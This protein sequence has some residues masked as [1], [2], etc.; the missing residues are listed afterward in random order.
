MLTIKFS[1]KGKKKH[2]FFK[3]IILEKSKD[4]YG[5]FL[6]DLGFH[7]PFSKQTSLKVDRIKY[8]LSHGA[9]TTP[10]VH[11]LLVDQGVVEGEKMR[12]SKKH[13]VKK[14]EGEEKKAEK[15]E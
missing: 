4:V 13:K 9:Q 6:E 8:W 10:V 14:D 11:N 2:P 12:I 3:I 15:K 5:D 1:R 7:D